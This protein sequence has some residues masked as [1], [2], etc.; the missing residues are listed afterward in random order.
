MPDKKYLSIIDANFNRCK[1]G[2]RVT[3]DIFR[4]V[5]KDDLLRGKARNFRHSLVHSVDPCLIKEAILE[6]DSAKDLGKKLDSFENKRD[7]LWDTLYRNL[8]RTKE[9]LRVLEEFSKIIDKKNTAGLKDLRYKI[10]DFEKEIILKW[11]SLCNN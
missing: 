1:E 10:Y 11:P 7:G 3:E 5:I 6:R 4:F 9:S 8:Q 2:L